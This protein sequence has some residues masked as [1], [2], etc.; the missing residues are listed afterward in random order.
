MSLCGQDTD[1]VVVP[2]SVQSM[3][4]SSEGALCEGVVGTG[5]TKLPCRNVSLNITC[6]TVPDEFRHTHLAPAVGCTAALHGN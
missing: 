2:A 6:V 1:L 3:G 4:S 5:F